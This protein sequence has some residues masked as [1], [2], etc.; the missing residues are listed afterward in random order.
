MGMITFRRRIADGTA[1]PSEVAAFERLSSERQAVMD[2]AAAEAVDELIASRGQKLLLAA[3][4]TS[5][6]QIAEGVRAKGFGGRD[7]QDDSALLVGGGLKGAQLPDNYR[8]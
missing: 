4:R 2:G 7:F 6:F 8:E 5:M 1:S 3:M